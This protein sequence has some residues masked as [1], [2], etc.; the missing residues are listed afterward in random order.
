[1]RRKKSLWAAICGIATF[2]LATSA[3]PGCLLNPCGGCMSQP[4][5]WYI[6]GNAG[7]THIRGEHLRGDFSTNNSGS[8]IGYN[9]NIGYKFMPYFAIEAGY[10]RYGGKKVTFDSVTLA[11]L[12]LDMYDLAGKGILPI[13][14]SG[15]ELFAKLGAQRLNVRISPNSNGNTFGIG[16][17][18]HTHYDYFIGIGGQYYLW[19]ELAIV[20]Q[21]QRANGSSTTGT[22]DLIS[23]GLSFMFA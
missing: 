13:M 11:Q 2:S 18:S 14:D 12:T 9:G 8:G 6:E 16:S 5:G 1:M 15:F 22:V 21:W 4:C 7:S 19:P 20:V 10:T 23:G 17:S 3:F